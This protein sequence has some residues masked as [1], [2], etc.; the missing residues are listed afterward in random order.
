MQVGETTHFLQSATRN[1]TSRDECAC[2]TTSDNHFG[3]YG[4]LE[5]SPLLDAN[6]LEAEGNTWQKRNNADR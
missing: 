6:H 4:S 2:I 5:A 3:G 1:C